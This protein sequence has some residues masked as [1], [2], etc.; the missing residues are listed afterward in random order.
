[1]TEL[2]AFSAVGAFGSQVW[3]VDAETGRRI[4]KYVEAYNGVFIFCGQGEPFHIGL[5]RKGCFVRRPIREEL[6][7]SNRFEQIRLDDDNFEFR[8][9]N[10]SKR[11]SWR[12]GI[13]GMRLVTLHTTRDCLRS[14]RAVTTRM[15]TVTFSNHCEPCLRL[16]SNRSSRLVVLS[17]PRETAD[18]SRNNAQ[19][20]KTWCTPQ[21][22]VR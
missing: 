20:R 3:L 10:N 22:R 8:D 16:P 4:H 17:S 15:S 13:K 6:F 7:R 9:Q 1:L 14:K 5:D 2:E 18:E 11:F 12:T 21:A 19:Q